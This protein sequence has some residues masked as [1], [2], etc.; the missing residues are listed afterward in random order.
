[1]I[2]FYFSLFPFIYFICQQAKE[3]EKCMVCGEGFPSRSKLFDHIKATG[4]AVALSV[5]QQKDREA[6]ASALAEEDGGKRKS[7]KKGKR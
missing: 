1:M 4:H 6:A 2:I 7:K 3:K 5:K